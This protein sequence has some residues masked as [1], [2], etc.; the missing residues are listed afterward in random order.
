MWHVSTCE[1]GH[2]ACEYIY[3]ACECGHVACE[4]M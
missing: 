3:V 1:C 4:Y 2:V